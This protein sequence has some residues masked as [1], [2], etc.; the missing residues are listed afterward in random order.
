MNIAYC[1]AR[2]LRDLF[3]NQARQ[4]DSGCLRT[5]VLT[6]ELRILQ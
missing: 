2:T 1:R 3:Q 5:H 4:P 6:V